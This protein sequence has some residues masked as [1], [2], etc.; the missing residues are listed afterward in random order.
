MLADSIKEKKTTIRCNLQKTSVA[1]LREELLEE[2]VK[3]EDGFYLDYAL[4]ISDYDSI[5][6]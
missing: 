2:N 5:E 3:V 6:N 1:K 4:R